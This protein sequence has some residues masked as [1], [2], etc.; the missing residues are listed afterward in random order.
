MANQTQ[1]N[2]YHPFLIFIP[3]TDLNIEEKS[4]SS[5]AYEESFHLCLF[6]RPFEKNKNGV[7]F[8]FVEYLP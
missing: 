5:G 2:V 6:E 3:E 7:F 8:L 1:A 4:A